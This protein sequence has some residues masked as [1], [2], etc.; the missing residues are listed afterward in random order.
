[1]GPITVLMDGW[2][3]GVKQMVKHIP[4]VVKST[5]R[6]VQMLSAT[7]S[8]VGLTMTIGQAYQE[9]QA[10]LGPVAPSPNARPSTAGLYVSRP[11]PGISQTNTVNPQR[12]VSASYLQPTVTAPVLQPT[13]NT[14]QGGGA[15]PYG[16]HISGVT[17]VVNPRLVF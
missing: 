10:T 8:S 4:D 9:S 11:Q 7:T 17:Q 1:M 5:E 15:L 3:L 2:G 6:V 12:T 14:I 16:A 13:Y